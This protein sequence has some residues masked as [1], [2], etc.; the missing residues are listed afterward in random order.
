M[1][2]FDDSSK[3]DFNLEVVLSCFQR[4]LRTD[5]RV[6]LEDYL[7]A[8]HELCRFFKLTGRL[9]G[10]VA[11]DI[12]SKMKAIEYHMH[13]EHGHHYDTVDSMVEYEVDK[14]TARHK[15]S[16][17]SG[18]RMMLRLHWALEFILAFMRQL[19]DEDEQAKTSKV[20]WDIYSKTLYHHHPWIT[21]KLAAVAVFA[22]PSKK[23]LIDVMCKH[24][25]SNV[26]VLLEQVL[27]AG[28]PVYDAVE[29]IMQE[30]NLSHIA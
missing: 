11:K 7:H 28:Q 12:E 10:F 30:S 20:A 21:S 23:H 18:C 1:G 22:L 29:R 2:S 14:G 16:H 4:C 27:D 8:Y 13:S 6:G 15:G 25:Y 17:P 26:M 9:F 5:K 3:H 24:D 19:L